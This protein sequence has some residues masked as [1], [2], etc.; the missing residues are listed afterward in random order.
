MKPGNDP[1]DGLGNPSWSMDQAHAEFAFLCVDDFM[2]D[3]VGGRALKTAFELRL[4]DLLRERQACSLEV[5]RRELACDERGLRLLLDLLRMNHVVDEKAGDIRLSSAFVAAMQYRDLLEAKLDFAGL[6]AADLIE[7]FT[8]LL[9]DP[10]NFMA[11]SRIFE[12]YNYTHALETSAENM[13]RTRT[14][15]R[16]TTCLTR[17]ESQACLK[18][19]DFSAYRRLLDIGG[20]SGEFVLRIC[21]SHARLQ[22]TV[23][24]LPAVCEIG[25]EHVRAE[26]EAARIAFQ[27]GDALT[28]PLPS[29]FDLVAFK[30]MLHDWPDIEAKRFLTRASQTLAPGGTLLIFE[31][32]PLAIG[33]GGLP[34][35]LIPILLFFRSFREPSFYDEHL[36]AIGFTNV[37]T[38]WINLDMPFFLLTA[39]MN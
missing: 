19:H 13:Q 4:I 29:G 7:R 36:R 20:N 12:L 24:D 5:L 38:Q 21:R 16:F 3:A 25:R 33:D 18:Y 15:M 22:A 6:V 37:R 17:Y 23:F 27:E 26:P 30:S 1:P 10:R 11:R 2:H 34:Y 14:W 35:S 31:R 32:G 9:T 28:D 8:L 39:T